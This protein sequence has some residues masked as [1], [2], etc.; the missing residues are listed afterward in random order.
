MNREKNKGTF[1]D[2][3][4]REN[5]TNPLEDETKTKWERFKEGGYSVEN[6]AKRFRN[7]L[8]FS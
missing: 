2:R 5:P 7:R 6:L 8:R 4:W 1:M 3:S